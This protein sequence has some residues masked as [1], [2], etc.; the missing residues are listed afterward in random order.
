MAL[1]IGPGLAMGGC[2]DGSGQAGGPSA[3]GQDAGPEAALLD[4]SQDRDATDEPASDVEEPDAGEPGDGALQDSAGPEP[5]AAAASDTGADGDAEP[6]YPPSSANVGWIGGSCAGASQCE[7]PDAMCLTDGFPNGMCSATCDEY[8][9]D[10]GQSGDTLS[11]C[12][13][14]RPYG[15]DEGVCV[16][17]C[18]TTVLPGS[19]CPA[20]YRCVERNRYADPATV[21]PVCVPLAAASPC[22][23]GSDEFIE[24]DYPDRGGL[25]IPQEAQC[26][27]SFDLVVMLHGINPNSLPA[28]D[29]GGGR[30]LEVEVRSYID[31]GLI[32]P[33]ILAEP[34][35][36]QGTST[37]L[38]G[39][40]FDLTTHLDLL[41]PELLSRGISVASLS[42]VGHSGAGCD[43]NNGLYKVLAQWHDLIPQYA[44]QMLLWGLEDVCYESSYHWTMP[45][46][47]LPATGASLINMYTIQGDPSAFEANL[48][49]A[50]ANMGCSTALYESCIAS[51]AEPWCSYRTQP[52]AGIT[53]ENNP[54]FFVREAFP[55]IFGPGGPNPCSAP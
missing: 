19:G 41:M 27:G 22:P 15:F 42:Y 5:D 30:H 37:Y 26:G 46:A 6:G 36:F 48:F 16:A 43:Q 31:A 18:D 21:V 13:D 39:P 12:I 45:M 33:L 2:G 7:I 50:P 1:A 52:S 49:P 38:Y 25:W 51:P 54:Y 17:R 23:G 34:V 14:G 29:L 20:G 8:C 40:D 47:D 9:P 28:P 10:R 32:K 4:V 35:H 55:Q 44:P 3:P 53:H 24:I 11:L